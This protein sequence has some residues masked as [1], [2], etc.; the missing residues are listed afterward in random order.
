M[1]VY[2]QIDLPLVPVLFR[3]EEAGVKLD[4]ELLAGLSQRLALDCDAKA[5]D[6]L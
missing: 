4:C 6:I 2:E 5:R 3:M 1:K